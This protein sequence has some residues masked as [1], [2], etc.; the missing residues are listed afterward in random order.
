LVFYRLIHLGFVMSLFSSD[1]LAARIRIRRFRQSKRI[2]LRVDEEGVLLSAPLRTSDRALESFFQ[3][4]RDWVEHHLSAMDEKMS[5]FQLREH[6][7]KIYFLVEGRW[8]VVE[9]R[10]EE[11]DW[12]DIQYTSSSIIVIYPYLLRNRGALLDRLLD[13]SGEMTLKKARLLIDER[14]KD[15]KKKPSDLR[16]S[17]AKTKWG[18]CSSKGVIHLHRRLFQLPQ[19]ALKYVVFHEL[20]HL[21]HLNHSPL[22]WKEVAQIMPNY[23]EGSQ[24]LLQREFDFSLEER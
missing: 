10:E 19:E 9:E 6:H 24:K 21:I 23:K 4:N 12:V 15:L 13:W 17:S 3:K 22:F 16:I 14:E 5:V 20:G 7:E 11:V 8:V 2:R 1:P 18:S